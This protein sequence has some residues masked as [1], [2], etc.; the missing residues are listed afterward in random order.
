MREPA[1]AGLRNSAASWLSKEAQQGQSILVWFRNK[2]GW[3][4]FGLKQVE[5]PVHVP[6]PKN[7]RG[8]NVEAWATERELAEIRQI[9]ADKPR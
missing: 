2:E 5:I 3:P 8:L 9:N 6:V 7:T 1:R 4:L